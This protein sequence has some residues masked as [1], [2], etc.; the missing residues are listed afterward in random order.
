MADPIDTIVQ[1]TVTRETRTPSQRGFGTP[2]IVAYHTA[3]TSDRVREYAD[4]SEMRDDGFTAGATGSTFLIAMVDAM[5]A[6][7]PSP[8]KV[9]I[10]RCAN[11]YQQTV[12]LIPR[13]DTEG[14][15]Y[16]V[17]IDGATFT[18]TVSGSEG[19]TGIVDALVTGISG[20]PGLSVTDGTTWAIVTGETGVLHT[21]VAKR[22]LDLYD[23][24][25]ASGLS[26]D[27]AAIAEEDELSTTGAA[28]GWL[29]DCNSQARIDVLDTFLESRIAQGTV[30][31][32]D[33]NVKDAGETG[34]IA[35]DMKSES[36]KRTHGIYHSQ[37]GVP[38]AA[39][40]QGRQLAINPGQSTWAHKTLATIP[41]D[42]LTTG[43]RSA[44]ESKNWSWYCVAAGTARTFEGKTPA[45][46]YA[47]IVRDIDFSIAEIRSAIDTCFINNE[48]VPQ[49]DAGIE[50]FRSAVFG[51]LLK[52][53]SASYPIFDASTVVVEELTVDDIPVADRANRVLRGLRYQARLQGA[54]HRVVVQGRV[55]V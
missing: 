1:V 47:D 9:K 33:W 15:E 12:H 19:L 11:G 48:K 49:T 25:G 38:I 17:A 53:S 27:L 6:Q 22:G 39:A 51:A 13:I 37:I 50:V 45:G 36:I 35:S 2:L 4:S 32:A 28:Y 3:W 46:E 29:L 18:Y 42:T 55:Y 24:T 40:W 54:F 44:I 34:D 43:Q 21:F 10:G 26:A 23:A 16:S 31:S 30:Q 5:K 52:C 8:A 7:E 14:Y 41:A 20:T